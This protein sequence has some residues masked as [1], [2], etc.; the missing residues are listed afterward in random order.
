MSWAALLMLAA[1]S[2]A[3][4]ASGYLVLGDR[5][6]IKRWAPVLDLFPPALLAALVVVQT[7]GLDRAL[8]VDALGNLTDSLGG[9]VGIDG[10]DKAEKEPKEPEPE[11]KKRRIHKRR[12]FPR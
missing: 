11:K 8:T 10:K 5:P 4:K 2:F 1:G 7:V 9:L 12:V 3:I 6:G